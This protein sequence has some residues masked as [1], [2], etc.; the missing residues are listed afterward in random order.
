MPVIAASQSPARDGLFER[1]RHD[2]ETNGFVALRKV[3][4]ARELAAVEVTLDELLLGSA[5]AGYAG[6]REL[7]ASAQSRGPR[8]PEFSRPTLA[9]RHLKR[10]PVFIKCREIATTLLGRPAHHLFDHAIYKMPKNETA[11]PWHQDLAYL[12]RFAT[13]IRS[14][15]FWIPMQD[16]SV[17]GGAM[18]FIPGSHKWAL[19]RHVP[20][21]AS[22][23]HVLQASHPETLAGDAVPL[24]RGD[25]TIHTHLTMH[26]AGP[27]R[28][29]MIRKAWIIHFGDKPGWYKHLMKCRELMRWRPQLRAGSAGETF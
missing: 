24:D 27:N 12:G 5:Y 11:T 23:P 29:D 7:S 6:R 17:D 22:N 21:F 25:V 9:A 10:S 28:S 3:F 20:A 26:G 15:H 13:E 8:Q 14:L 2:L 18:R 4:D 16:T 19:A 1:T